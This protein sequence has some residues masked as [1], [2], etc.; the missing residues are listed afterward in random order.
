MAL[1]LV[2]LGRQQPMRRDLR[3][4]HLRV[5]ALYGPM[6][7]VYCRVVRGFA[8]ESV[9]ESASGMGWLSRCE[10]YFLIC[11]DANESYVVAIHLL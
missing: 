7:N 10:S 6:K 4:V 8:N 3:E 1:H 9:I 5:V 2:S 11:R